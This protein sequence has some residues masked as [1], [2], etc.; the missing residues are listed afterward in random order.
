[1]GVRYNERGDLYTEE[2]RF[3]HEGAPTA[4]GG[5]VFRQP[6]QTR[7]KDTSESELD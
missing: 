6:H 5:W 2:P 3:S 7:E 1:M 4:D